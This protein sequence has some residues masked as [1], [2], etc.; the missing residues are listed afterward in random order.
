MLYSTRVTLTLTRSVSEVGNPPRSRFGLVSESGIRTRSVSEARNRA[1]R[2]RFGLVSNQLASSITAL[3]QV[4]INFR[5]G[6]IRGKIRKSL[7]V[8]DDRTIMIM[9]DARQ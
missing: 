9:Q 3:G 5:N 1:P 7:T 8:T 6:S 4:S 2:L